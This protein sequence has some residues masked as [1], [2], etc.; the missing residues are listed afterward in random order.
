MSESQLIQ[1]N[2]AGAHAFA[3]CEFVSAMCWIFLQAVLHRSR[4]S[5][6]CRIWSLR[7]SARAFGL[8]VA[9]LTTQWW[10]LDY[11]DRRPAI[12]YPRLVDKP[13]EYQ[14]EWDPAKA[15]Q[16]ARKHWITFERAA[17]V[18]L[19]PD[20]LSVFDE[21][22]SQDEDRWITLGLDRAG[23]LIVVCHTYREQTEINARVRII[24]ARK[25]TKT[26]AKQYERK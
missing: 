14:V 3:A 23:T 21:E 4:F 24:S 11:L 10:L 19:D 20:A 2:A 18:F 9:A 22:H 1:S 25:A 6:S 15:R 13:F 5:M 26:E 7:I 16:N 12:S 17:T 8:Q